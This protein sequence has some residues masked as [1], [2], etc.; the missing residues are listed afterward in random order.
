MALGCIQAL[1]CNKNTYP[2]GIT[3][4]DK[5]LQWGLVPKSKASRI[6]SFHDNLVHDVELISHSCGVDEPRK[7]RRHHARQVMENGQSIALDKLYPYP[8]IASQP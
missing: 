4:H 7:L 6:A 8:E 1:Q 2:T 3:T 5:K